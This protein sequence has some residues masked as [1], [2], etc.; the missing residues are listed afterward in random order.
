LFGFIAFECC[1]LVLHS[2]KNCIN[3]L[4]GREPFSEE[5]LVFVPKYILHRLGISPIWAITCAIDNENEGA[6]AQAFHLVSAISYARATGLTYLHSPFIRIAHAD[7]PMEEWVAAWESVF[8][9]GAGEPPY[10]GRDRGVIHQ[11]FRPCAYDMWRVFDLCF[12]WKDRQE[13]FRQR[14]MAL[15]PE[16]RRKY[17]V[18]KSPRTNDEVT[19]A[20]HIRRGD[21]TQVHAAYKYTTTECVLRI[22]SAIKDTL[23][24]HAA[25]GSIRI[26]SQGAPEDFAELSSLGAELVLNA[27]PIWTF[28]ELV[29][30]DILVA[31]KSCYSH[32]AGFMSDGIKIYE[33]SW[34]WALAP[35]TDD[36]I[37]CE[38]DGAFDRAAFERQLFLLLEEKEKAKS[39]SQVHESK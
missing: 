37:P 28:Q 20:V 38:Q 34:H 36:W 23:D 18:N 8:N 32:Y 1:R 11:N 14:M 35:C 16:F 31:A 30:A 39:A 19:V 9:L 3:R 6:G 21:V 27:D 13:E 10:D 29:E 12:G 24:A 17:Y 4:L 7:R 5:R 15:V 33:G 26:Y 22:A 2:L 25:P